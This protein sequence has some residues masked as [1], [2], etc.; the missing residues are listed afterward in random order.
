MYFTGLLMVQFRDWNYAINGL[1]WLVILHGIGLN[2]ERQR[3]AALNEDGAQLRVRHADGVPV[4]VRNE[5][6]REFPL[7]VERLEA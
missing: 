4:A 3:A 2:L 6:R 1:S 5:P 7:R